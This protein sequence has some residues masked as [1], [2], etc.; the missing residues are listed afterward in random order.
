[1]KKLLLILFSISLFACNNNYNKEK[2]SNKK[3]KNDSLRNK[4]VKM[5]DVFISLRF[6]QKPVHFNCFNA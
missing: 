2:E 6:A 5:L 3:S 4:L 1:M